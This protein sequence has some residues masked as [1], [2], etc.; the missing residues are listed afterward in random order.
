M[1]CS[2]S[3]DRCLFSSIIK[4]LI[5]CVEIRFSVE[6]SSLKSKTSGSTAIALT[7]F[8]SIEKEI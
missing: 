3:Q 2:V 6:V 1:N 8:S 7:L 4:R 5:S